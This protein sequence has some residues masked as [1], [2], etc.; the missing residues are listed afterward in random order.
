MIARVWTASA[1]R[2]NASAY[3]EHFE[4]AVVAGLRRIDGYLGASLLTRDLGEETEIVVMTRWRSLDAIRAF[5]GE[6]IEAAV[7]AEDAQRLL[8]S[9][10]RQVRHY[11]VAVDVTTEANRRGV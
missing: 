4:T 8:S 6:D 10:D 7:V 5:A 3:R 11:T 2:L 9:W 1:T